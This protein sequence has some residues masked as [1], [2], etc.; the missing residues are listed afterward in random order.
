MLLLVPAPRA[1]DLA[2][3][4]AVVEGKAYSTGKQIF[5]AENQAAVSMACALNLLHCLDRM[6]NQG[7]ITDTQLRVLFAIT[8][9]GPI[10]ELWA[11]WTV[12]KGG[13]RVFES[14]LWDS[15]NVLVL[16]RAED[17]IVKLNS[18]CLWGTGPFL[19]TV[20]EPLGKVARKAREATA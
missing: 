6:A 18:V 1:L 4:F 10:H 16:E 2:F 7:T 11:Y 3:P 17:F 8:T 14:K 20:V 15:W 13:V 19:K 12:V 9:Q 5:E